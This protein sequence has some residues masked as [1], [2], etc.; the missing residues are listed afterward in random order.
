MTVEHDPGRHR[1]FVRHQEGESE[2]TYQPA[3]DDV[4]DFLHTGVPRPLRGQGIAE[5]LVKAALDFAR[6][7]GKRVIP[8][9]P[10]VASWIDEHPEEGD[11]VAA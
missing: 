5:A 3:G 1:F 7:E 10:F 11:L 8:S 4:L 6:A 9:C 2:L